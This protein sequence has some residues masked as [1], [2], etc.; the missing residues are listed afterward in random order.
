MDGGVRRGTDI[1]KVLA[2]GAK[3]VLIGRPIL[4]GLAVEG[5]AGVE[6]IF[7]ILRREYDIA[8]ANVGVQSSVTIPRDIIFTG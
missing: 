2:F 7:A 5:Q 1:L 8:L 4:W 3:A 6:N